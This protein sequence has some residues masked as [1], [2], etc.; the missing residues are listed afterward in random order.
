MYSRSK[1]RRNAIS[2]AKSNIPG[3]DDPNFSQFEQELMAIARNEARQVTA[4]YGPKLEILNGKHKPLLKAYERISKDYDAHAAKIGRSEPSVELSRGKYYVLML[5][6]VLGEIPMNSLAFAVFGE[7]QIFTWIMAVGV[8]VAIPWIAHAMGILLKRWSGPWWKN[9]LGVGILLLLT[10]GGLV[11]IGYVRVQYL[12]DLSRA[13]AVSSFGSSTVIGAAFVG[14]NL[15]ILAAATLCS[16]FAHDKD[17][18]LEHL[19][20]RTNQLNKSMRSIEA[21][22]RKIL[23][24]QQQEIHRIQQKAQ[25][26]IFYYRKINQ[27]VRPDHEKPKSFEREHELGV[28]FAQEEQ[29]R[30]METLTTR[31]QAAAN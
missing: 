24:R 20:R 4:A 6:F 29:G 8:A 14:L 13:G 7:S 10:V 12:G 25:E 16:Y 19:H 11:A 3:R 9:A 1:A 27:R 18:M 30:Q 28:D 2:D 23:T 31:L 21:K 15:V 22:Y 17:P 5:L 26:I